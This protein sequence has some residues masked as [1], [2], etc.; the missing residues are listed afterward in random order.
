MVRSALVGRI[1][2]RKNRKING[3]ILA[4]GSRNLGLGFVVLAAALSVLAEEQPTRAPSTVILVSLDGTRPADL[5]AL[6]TLSKL[7]QIGLRAEEMTPV[8]PSNTFPNHVSLVT[9]VQPQKHGIVNNSFRDPARGVW[10]R[11]FPQS[12]SFGKILSPTAL[13]N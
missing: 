6:P 12:L 13:G 10:G 8:F 1:P 5:G 9:G 3:S 4:P 11:W 2:R 7:A